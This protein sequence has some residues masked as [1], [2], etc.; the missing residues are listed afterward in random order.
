MHMYLTKMRHSQKLAFQ[1]V[2]VPDRL[3]TFSCIGY[4]ANP[5]IPAVEAIRFFKR[6]IDD[7]IGIW[8]GSRRSFDNFVNLLNREAAKFG[9][10]FPVKEIQ[11]GKSVHML[12]LTVYLDDHNTIH[13]KGYTKPTDAKRYLN[14]QSFH[15]RSV[16][17]SIPYSQMIRTIENNSKEETRDMQMNELVQHF[18]NSG[19]S[20]RQLDELKHK[21]MV[22][23]TT[24]AAMTNTDEINQNN[25]SL[26]FPLYYFEG[27]QEFKS[28]IH[29]LKDDF[30]QLIGDTRVMFAMK[31]G[32]SIGNSMVRNKALCVETVA[33][34]DNQKCN[35]PGCLQCPLTNTQHKL[36]INNTNIS[37]PRSL[38]CKSRNVIYLWKCKLC[39]SSDC[40]FGRT[41]QK[42]HI[43]TNG[44][45]GC[46]HDEEKIEN[47]ALSMHAKE[48]HGANFNLENFQ[49]SVIKSISP[50]NIRRE[51]FRYIEKYR[52]IQL[53][54]NR[55]K[56]S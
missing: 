52:T 32:V 40:Y 46:F 25:E 56:A 8:R 42:C 54:L 20:R 13:Y 48:A 50:Q 35:G 16:F 24:A 12:E 11:F 34:F 36:I 47:S 23:T 21:A 10:K 28:L 27:I 51:E 3:R 31:K 45:R 38:N 1:Q 17:T 19:Y 43:R 26:V 37:I 30:R 49:I 53:G 22:K 55:Y 14:T 2:G 41:T 29:D 39:H 33:P 18:E 4:L 44:H 9:I 6:F 15:P 7:C 5:S